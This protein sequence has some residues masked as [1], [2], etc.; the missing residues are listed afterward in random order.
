MMAVVPN[1]GFG[2]GFVY[3]NNATEKVEFSNQ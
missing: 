1:I 2:V 3:P